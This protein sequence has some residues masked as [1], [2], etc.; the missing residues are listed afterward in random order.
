LDGITTQST[1][2]SFP[3]P[4]HLSLSMATGKLN[5]I[6]FVDMASFNNERI[7]RDSQEKNIFSIPLNFTEQHL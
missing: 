1:A 2:A 5:L 4:Y 7:I 3:V 6:Y